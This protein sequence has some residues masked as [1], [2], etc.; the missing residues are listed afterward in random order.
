V[1]LSGC[2]QDALQAVSQRILNLV[3]SATIQWWGEE[4]SIGIL[5][6]CTAAMPGDTVESLLQR[7]QPALTGN[8]LSLPVRAIAMR[9]ADPSGKS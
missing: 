1:I 5:L 4:L 9:G 6:G 3:S 7:A 2:P 8:Q